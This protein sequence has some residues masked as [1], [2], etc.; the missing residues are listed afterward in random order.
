MKDKD[1]FT[2][3][4]IFIGFAFAVFIVLLYS[5][6]KDISRTIIVVDK[7]SGFGNY[8]YD[9][10]ETYRLCLGEDYFDYVIGK[11]IEIKATNSFIGKSCWEKA[12]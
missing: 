6:S 12:N 11:E 2:Y 7:D 5:T 1:K 9:G 3:G 10:N 4:A 8:I